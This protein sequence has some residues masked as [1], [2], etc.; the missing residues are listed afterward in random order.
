M[1]TV[2]LVVI[3]VI[4]GLVLGAT[5]VFFYF[6]QQLKS[7]IK[8]KGNETSRLQEENTSLKTELSALRTKLDEQ[9]KAAEEKLDLLDNAKVKLSEAF[10]AL[11]AEALKNNNAQFLTLANTRLETFQ[12]T[13]TGELEKR[14]QAIDE[15]VAPLKQGLKDID[16][17][18]REIEKKR[19]GAYSGL[20]EQIKNIVTNEGKLQQETSN[21]VRALRTPHVRGR[22][23]EIQLKRVVEIAGMLNYCDFIEQ[24]TGGERGRPDMIVKLPN[25]RSIVVDSKVPLQAYLD[26]IEAKDDG[27]RLAKLKE[28][29]GQVRTHV[30]NL[31]AKSYWQQFP[32]APEF[33][34]LFMPGEMFF[35]AA[36]QQDPTLIEAGA[37]QR[38]ILATPTTLISLLKAVAYGWRQEQITENA[39]RISELGRELYDRIKI[40]AEH[41][42]ALKKNLDGA[43]KAFNDAAGS[44]ET[45]VLVTTRK[46]REL[47][48][49]TGD[50]IQT[51][52]T[53]DTTTRTLK[54]EG[55]EDTTLGETPPAADK[56]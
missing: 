38:V 9:L 48:A 47:G 36:L 55:V 8:E 4:T 3:G 17:N 30:N 18:L 11:S 1:E 32:S 21:L 52:S 53:I 44:L 51:L 31:A 34:V 25:S 42:A 56:I 6:Q 23:G 54:T 16:N 27:I 15:L 39:M 12:A 2:L 28:H 46:F 41:F 14:K 10:Q 13:A 45:R 19:E 49:A 37:A 50:E 5:A 26:A 33:V 20:T 24:Q 22:W 7:V 40:F 35:S 29:A 43:V